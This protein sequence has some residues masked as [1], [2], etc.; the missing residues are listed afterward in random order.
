MEG[1]ATVASTSRHAL[2]Q[3]QV[4]SSGAPTTATATTTTTASTS[5]AAIQPVHGTIKVCLALIAA[6]TA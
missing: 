4:G 6:L 3:W 2:E 1:K 5:A